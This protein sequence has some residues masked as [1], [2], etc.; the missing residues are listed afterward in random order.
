MQGVSLERHINDR[1]SGLAERGVGRQ[2]RSGTVLFH[3]HDL[4]DWVVLITTGRVKVSATGANGK[5]VVLGICGPGDVLGELSAVDSGPRSATVTAID[6]VKAQIVGADEFRAF[7]ASNPAESLALLRSLCGRLRDSDRRRVEYI[8]L[9]TIGRL[10]GRLVELADSY[11]MAAPDGSASLDIPL[12]QD[13]L[14]GM[15]GASREAVGKALQLFRRRAWIKTG[16]RSIQI[17]QIEAL[18][19]RST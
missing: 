2:Y 7:L 8:A 19:A 18:R 6:D 11:G 15:I 16:R 10:A 1:R 3:E 9:D 4:S 13:D 17:L 12:T 14:A 5:E